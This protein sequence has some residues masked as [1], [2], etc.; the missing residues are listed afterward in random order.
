MRLLFLFLLPC[1]ASAQSIA[2]VKYFTKEVHN[3]KVN[4]DSS[5]DWRIDTISYHVP[6][7][8]KFTKAK[9]SIDGYGTYKIVKYEDRSHEGT[10]IDHWKLSDGSTITRFET[11]MYWEYPVVN[12]KSR[13]I[14][15]LLE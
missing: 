6:F 5:L 4:K 2:S 10:Q 7:E 9:V 11:L 14:H 3:I 12:R 8:V 1:A 15:F 13:I